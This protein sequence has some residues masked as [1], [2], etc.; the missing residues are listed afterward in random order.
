MKRASEGFTLIEIM[1]VIA[2]IG[3]LATVTVPHYQ[4]VLDH[5]RL[6]TAANEVL[7]RLRQAKQMAMDERKN[8]RVEM[9]Q[10]QV[11]LVR[12]DKDNLGNPILTTI[13]TYT[14]DTRITFDSAS[15]LRLLSNDVGRYLYFD[16]R[17][18]LKFDD[19]GYSQQNPGEIVADIALNSTQ[20]SARVRVNLEAGTADMSISWP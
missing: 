14:F 13:D 3:I 20:T 17:G 10:N 18:F 2:V 6:E 1:I 4:S 16:Y 9:T 11:Q 8:C 15:S 5:Y 19:T 12:E 7:V